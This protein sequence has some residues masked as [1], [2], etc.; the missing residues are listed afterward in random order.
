LDIR[1][2]SLFQQQLDYGYNIGLDSNVQRSRTRIIL[3]I[4]KIFFLRFLIVSQQ[5]VQNAE[6]TIGSCTM[7]SSLS[8]L[9]S[10]TDANKINQPI[11]WNESISWMRKKGRYLKLLT[12]LG[13]SISAWY[14]K[15]NLT[16][17]FRPCKHAKCN[18][19][20]PDSYR[21]YQTIKIAYQQQLLNTLT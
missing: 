6:M 13:I 5:G 2:C 16:Y 14:C 10:R 15:N 19:V 7:Q 8:I 21:Y 20:F 1:I 4:N 9:L 3:H 17:S 12:I 18:R 11:K